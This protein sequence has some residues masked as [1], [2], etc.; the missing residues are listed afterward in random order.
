MSKLDR[1]EY[2]P[3]AFTLENSKRYSLYGT[4]HGLQSQEERRRDKKI[5]ALEGN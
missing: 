2:T 1:Y 3:R 4:L 5:V